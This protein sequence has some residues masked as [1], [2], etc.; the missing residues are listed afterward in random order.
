[1]WYSMPPLGRERQRNVGLAMTLLRT[2][3]SAARQQ[4]K[5]SPRILRRVRGS[6][7]N[8]RRRTSLP[9]P[10]S[11]ASLGSAYLIGLKAEDCL[12]G[13]TMAVKQEQAASKD[14]VLE[15]VDRA[16]TGL[17]K[18]LGESLS[19]I[20]KFDTPL[21]QATTPSLEALK[22]YSLGTKTLAIKGDVAAIPFYQRAIDLDPNFAMAYASLGTAYG[23]LRE[24]D[25]A[26]ENYQKAFDLRRRV[27][28]RED[29]VISAFY[30]NDVTG[31]LEKSDQTYELFSQAYPRAWTPH[32]NLGC[33]YASLGQWDKAVKETLEANRLGPD[34]RLNI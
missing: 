19:T 3:S 20:Q 28:I 33:N 21:A 30:Y 32:N 27:S 7:N 6:S 11:I 17:R 16:T 29:Y 22:S 5:S 18:D 31:D 4:A 8:P 12:T 13:A 10:E 23:N 2:R 26:T 34:S 24:T 14:E 25:L 1:M 15:A 9:A